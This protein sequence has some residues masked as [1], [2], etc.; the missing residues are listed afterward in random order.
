M[1][2][3]PATGTAP[4]GAD[5]TAGARPASAADLDYSAFL[6]LLVAQM[7]SQ[8]PLSP[9]DTTQYMSQLASFSNVEQS[10][11]VNAKLD[12]LLASNAALQGQSL[13]GHRIASA[14]QSVSGIVE[15]VRIGD[16]GAVAILS[17]GRELEVS[18]GV[19]ITR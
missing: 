12:A 19:R 17:D 5:R 18:A 7:K 15:A 16:S 9:Q 1:N 11:Q 13:I 6:T 10:V 2:V 14:D 3:S 8:D 4:T